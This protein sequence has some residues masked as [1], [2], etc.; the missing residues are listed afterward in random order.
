LLEVNSVEAGYG[1]LQVLWGVSLK[2]PDG[3]FVG[4]LG[5]NGAGKS[6][7]LRTI[8]GLIKPQSGEVRFM[9]KPVTGLK[10]YEISKMGLVFITE[11]LNLFPLMT[12]RENLLLGA[13]CVRDT[14]KMR[15]SMD[16]VL[17]L[18]PVLEEREV[19]LAG[20]LSGGERKMLAIGRG[21]MADPRLMMVDEPS[22]GLGP[23]VVES[24]F[25]ALVELNKRGVAILL[26]EQSVGLALRTT[27]RSYVLEQGQIVLE[28]ASSSLLRNEHVRQAY[29]SIT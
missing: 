29:L 28:D 26:V 23:K 12:V 1:H 14:K 13:Y 21:L 5:P 20:T 15:A 9:G 6:T 22:L 19:Q 16:Y 24:I 4:L 8:S 27:D 25:R 10:T 2:V 18:F 7:T 11:E 17:D 3:G